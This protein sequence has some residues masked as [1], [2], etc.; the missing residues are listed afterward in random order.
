MIRVAIAGG[1][2]SGKTSLA[3]HLTTELYNVRKK[4]AQHVTEFARDYINAA[5]RAQNGKFHPSMADQLLMY[6]Q[7][8]E[9][10]SNL[11][12][13]VKYMFTDSPLFLGMVFATNMLDPLNFQSRTQCLHLFDH[14]LTNHCKGWY[15]LIVVV[16]REKPF[17]ND[18]TRGES[19][20]EADDIGEKIESLLNLFNLPYYLVFGSDTD[21]VSQVIALIEDHCGVL[22]D[23]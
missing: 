16:R 8:V 4:N 10:E 14:F 19:A 12:D 2:G 9:R 18:G 5:R 22:A 7:Q 15:D 1:P 20:T 13:E 6:H 11:P 17:L 3:R 21:R 23:K